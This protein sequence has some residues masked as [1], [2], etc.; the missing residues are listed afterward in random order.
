M[1]SGFVK[2]AIATP[3]VKVADCAYNREE[4]ETI[5]HEAAEQDVEIL[6]FP[7]LA[8]TS[9]TCGDLFYQQTLITAAEEE[10]ARLSDNTC[11]LPLLVIVGMPVLLGERLFNA[12]VAFQ[13]GRLLA[14]VPKTHIPNY[15][16]F[17]EKRWFSSA[18]DETATEVKLCGQ[19]VP[20]GANILLRSG[21]VCVG[22]E[23]CEDL[24]QPSPPSSQLALNGANILFNLSA[25]NETVAKNSY[26]RSL[27]VQQSARCI[28]GYAYTSCGMGESSTDLVFS[29]SGFICENGILLKESARFSLENELTVSEIDVERLHFDR[30]KCNSFFRNFSPE[31]L[32]RTV[33]FQLDEFDSIELTRRIEPHPFVPSGVM[34]NERCDEIF[35]IQTSGLAKRLLHTGIKKVTLGVSG[36]LDST[37]ALLVCVKT[38]DKLSM[39]R[40]QIIAVT[41]PGF[42]TTGRTYNNAVLLT[43]ALGVQLREI[44]IKPACL[45][46][47]KDINHSPDIHD[48]TYENTQARERTQ[49]LMDIAN[50]EGGLVVGTGD[51]SE[52]ALG[53][54]TYSGDHISM[55]GVNASIPKTLIRYLISRTA[56]VQPQAV[57]AVLQDIL[58]T[59]VSPELLPAA[60]S[61]EIIQKTEEV[62]GPYELHDFFLYYFIRWG[63]SPEKI[64][65]LAQQAFPQC[66]S[67][68]IIQWMT[69]F[70]KR[71]F[72]QQFKRSCF[73]DGPK[74]GSVSLSPR[75]DWRMPSDASVQIW[76]DKIEKLE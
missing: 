51:L 8:I 66:S 75:G 74:V 55:Y 11:H 27:V 30:E 15:S 5:V 50:K 64:F 45:Q 24:W 1:Y 48:I 59:P 22:M 9:Y 33:S 65:F 39:P 49:L 13:G 28:A 21:K 67:K 10:M 35:N 57:A 14:V 56:E 71:F 29:G 18:T 72:S 63:F 19:K 68:K 37:L 12:A 38:F 20:F 16:E 7:E 76:L 26:R 17:Y 4:M 44:D 47:F 69:V 42:G 62:L 2:I 54:C 23:I 61:G 46:H 60:K 34:L 70:F 25:S 73:P 3:K 53:W 32:P 6:C 36:G 31:Q 40:E 58:D 41:M 43:K 52:L